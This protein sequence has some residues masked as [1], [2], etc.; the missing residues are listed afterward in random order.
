MSYVTRSSVRVIYTAVPGRY[1]GKEPHTETKDTEWESVLM[2]VE[3]S[4]REERRKV[5]I[6]QD[7]LEVRR[8]PDCGD[9]MFLKPLI[10]CGSCACT[11]PL[12]C[13]AYKSRGVFYAECL[14]LSLLSRG[15]T[16]EDAVARLQEQMF[17]YVAAAFDGD[18]KGLI[19]RK[20]P[21]SSWI[22]YYWRFFKNRL[23]HPRRPHSARE[24]RDVGAMLSHC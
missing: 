6:P 10:Q 1:R 21:T 24:L 19:P 11:L 17:S 9:V 23:S 2:P 14:D 15:Q 22:R 16:E 3:E 8:C 12:R 20:A 13:F 5:T 7:V 4:R 18:P